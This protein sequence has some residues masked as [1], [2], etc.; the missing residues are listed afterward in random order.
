M[1]APGKPVAV[2]VALEEMMGMLTLPVA[3]EPEPEVKKVEV[4]APKVL[5]PDALSA[6][7]VTADEEGLAVEIKV[8]TAE[9]EVTGMSVKVGTAV[10][11]PMRNCRYSKGR[12]A[13]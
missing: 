4:E 9:V 7:M 10:L 8:G 3:V 6:T 13:G 1:I 5:E 12:S 11:F 2:A